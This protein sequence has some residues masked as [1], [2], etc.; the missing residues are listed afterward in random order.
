MSTK[1]KRNSFSLKT[2]YKIIKL[3]DNQ[4][5]ISDIISE[6][7]GEGV[8]AKNVYQF[9]S[10]KEKIIKAYENSITSTAKSLKTCKYPDIDKA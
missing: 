6:F 7:S 5:N 3:L 2:K 8:T 9:K 1:R 10:Q 4:P